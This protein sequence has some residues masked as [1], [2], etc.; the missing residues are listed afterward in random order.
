MTGIGGAFFSHPH[1]TEEGIA[2]VIFQA[3]H[4]AGV[5][6]HADAFNVGALIAQ[7]LRADDFQEGMSLGVG[8]P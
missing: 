8:A 7:I 1:D 3:D 5:K 4:I 2:A 6:R